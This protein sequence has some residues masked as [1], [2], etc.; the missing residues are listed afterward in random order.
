MHQPN[1]FVMFSY[2]RIGEVLPAS[3]GYGPGAT[4]QKIFFDDMRC[5]GYET[6]LQHCTHRGWE[7]HNCGHS[8]DVSIAC[9]DTNLTGKSR[10]SG[11]V[12]D[13]VV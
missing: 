7:S 11:R 13:V 9:H 10:I 3:E 1:Q 6:S 5:V 4:N 2:R 12:L 8:E